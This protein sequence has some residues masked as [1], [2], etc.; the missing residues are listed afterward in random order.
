MTI[1]AEGGEDYF[2]GFRKM[3]IK[4]DTK[5]VVFPLNSPCFAGNTG[6]IDHL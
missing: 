4:E 1:E 5:A 2:N 3:F 6:I